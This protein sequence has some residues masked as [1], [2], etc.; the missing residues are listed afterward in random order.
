[1][2]GKTSED[3]LLQLSTEFPA[4]PD[5]LSTI[6]LIKRDYGEVH[7]TMLSERL[8][9]SKPAVSQAVARLKHAG[10]LRQD[11]YA[12]IELTE[13]GR[14]LAETIIRRH[15]LIEHLLISSIDYPW[16]NADEEALRL[17]TVISEDLADH[18]YNSFGRPSVCPHGNPFPGSE[19]EPRL[20]GAPRLTAC[21]PDTV[22]TIVRITEEGE[23]LGGLLRFCRENGLRPGT[24]VSVTSAAKD[25]CVKVVADEV[26]IEIPWAIAVHLAVEE[27][28][29]QASGSM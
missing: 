10:L 17:Q 23:G 2:I 15:Y 9:V 21:E 4:A 6:L 16:E 18:L 13:E 8:G 11:S 14:V 12:P 19:A 1:M 28:A 25:S 7:N 3:R 5:Y 26:A 27:S 22:A 29:D 24:R 20:L